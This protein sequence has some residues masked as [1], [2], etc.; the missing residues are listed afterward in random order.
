MRSSQSRQPSRNFA[1]FFCRFPL[2]CL[3]ERLLKSHLSL[4]AHHESPVLV[5]RLKLFGNLSANATSPQL[6]LMPMNYLIRRP[7]AVTF[8]FF[9]SS[10]AGAAAPDMRRAST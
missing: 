5:H 7:L 8:L 6:L 2:R 3:P 1:H 10:L 9:A 4:V